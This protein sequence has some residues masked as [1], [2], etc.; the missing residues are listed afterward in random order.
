MTAGRDCGGERDCSTSIFHVST[1][2]GKYSLRPDRYFLV[3]QSHDGNLI[4]SDLGSS[5]LSSV[6]EIT[7]SSLW[8]RQHPQ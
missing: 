8:T 3:R 5:D 2:L 4:L 7:H 1:K 6:I